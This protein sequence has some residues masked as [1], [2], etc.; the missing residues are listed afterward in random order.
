MVVKIAGQRAKNIFSTI[1]KVKDVSIIITAGLLRALLISIALLKF[2]F[3]S[4]THEKKKK[5][6]QGNLSRT[7][8]KA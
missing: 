6:W 7:R 3:Q 1:A 2:N 4:V 5:G 8:A